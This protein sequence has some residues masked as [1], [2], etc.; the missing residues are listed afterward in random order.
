MLQP[1]GTFRHQRRSWNEA[2][3]AHELTF[4]CYDRLPLLGRDRSRRWL[5]HALDAARREHAFELWAY[6]VMPEHVHVLLLP[7]RDDYRIDQILKSI[8]QSVARKAM[9]FL[10]D[11]AP[12]WL[13][14]LAVRR[15]DGRVEHRF[16][17]RGGG[18]DRNITSARTAWFSVDYLHNNPVRRGLVERATD[19]AWSS[20]RWYAGWDE[21]VLAMD[22]RPPDP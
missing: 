1:D 18:Y 7:R 8:K 4:S 21:L 12:A 16:W 22:D 17:E 20:A 5:I 14:R 11:S 13:D 10:R 15:F 2:G 9:R 6:V 3:H 19:W